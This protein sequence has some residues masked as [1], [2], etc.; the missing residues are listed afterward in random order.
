MMK[1]SNKTTAEQALKTLQ[2]EFREVTSI[3]IPSGIVPPAAILF[4]IV[5]P[6]AGAVASLV[7]GVGVVLIWGFVAFI[8]KTKRRL[9]TPITW[10]LAIITIGISVF[11]LFY[12]GFCAG[13]VIAALDRLIKNRNRMVTK[14]FAVLAG[15]MA[16]LLL[17]YFLP[18]PDKSEGIFLK[19]FCLAVGSIIIIGGA[20]SYALDEFSKRRFCESCKVFMAEG[21]QSGLTWADT[22]LLQD[23]IAQAQ[24][25]NVSTQFLQKSGSD[26][27]LKVWKCPK[28][29]SGYLEGFANFKAEWEENGNSESLTKEWLI[30]SVNA[31][32]EKHA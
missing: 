13:Y 25:M 17:A 28:C 14:T 1:V 30:L 21:M 22:K 3:Y 9:N 19:W 10:V 16:G 12:A 24:E 27:R 15:I 31:R 23:S 32:K 2:S 11:T 18:N 20:T 7:V 26:V 4:I 8:Q 29:G 6:L 5:S